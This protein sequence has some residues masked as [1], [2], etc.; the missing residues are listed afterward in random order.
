MAAP[1]VLVVFD[2]DYSLVDVDSEIF[3]V[4]MLY[5]ELLLE[6]QDT[7][8]TWSELVKEVSRRLYVDRPHITADVIKTTAARV[9][10][11]RKMLDALRLAAESFGV[12]VKIVSDANTVYIQSLLD[13][14][15]LSAHVSEVV[16]NPARFDDDDGSGNGRRLRVDPHHPS[17]SE[18]H[19]CPH[20]PLNM[21]KGRILNEILQRKD[22]FARVLY[23]GDGAGDF[24]PATRLSKNDMVFARQDDLEGGKSFELL[25]KINAH[26]DQVHASVVP[27]ISGEDIYTRFHEFFKAQSAGMQ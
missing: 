6:F 17:D 9:P 8:M 4:Q 7:T 14:Y 21:C 22:P 16:T 25:A 23:V 12:E 20:C 5:P 13:H 10:V 15:E 26:R 3:M 18:P 24:C 2:Y 11:Q 27:W 1:R 19:G